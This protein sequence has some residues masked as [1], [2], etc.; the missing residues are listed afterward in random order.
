MK[1]DYLILAQTAP[2]IPFEEYVID[3]E[4]MNQ[5]VEALYSLIPN[6]W[7]ALSIYEV[8]SEGTIK[9]CEERTYEERKH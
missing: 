7:N 1:R 3:A 2:G 8:T 5:A 4:D 6:S 9:P